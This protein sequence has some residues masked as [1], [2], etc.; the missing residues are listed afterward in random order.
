M[1]VTSVHREGPS[2]AI[3]GGDVNSSSITAFAVI[4]VGDNPV[5]RYTITI[6]PSLK[7]GE[8]NKAVREVIGVRREGELCIRGESHGTRANTVVDICEG[9]RLCKEVDVP[10][11]I[12]AIRIVERWSVAGP[13]LK[14]TTIVFF[15]IPRCP[16]LDN[17]RRLSHTWIVQISA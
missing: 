13:C 2:R 8:F 1:Q 5:C 3:E 15:S 11:H 17:C 6:S 12:L 7:E 4:A 14:S 16:N 10:M 9:L